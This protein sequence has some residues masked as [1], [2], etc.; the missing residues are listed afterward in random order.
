MAGKIFINYRRGD[1]A[2]AAQALAARLEQAFSPEQLFMDVDN[3]EPG[4]DFVRVLCE[5]VA[6]CDVLI[7]VIGKNWIDARDEHGARRLD[8][9]SDLVRVEIESALHQDKRV[10]PVLGGKAQ[11][12]SAEQLPD[13]MRPLTTRNAVRLTHERFRADMQGL[14]PRCNVR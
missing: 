11:T 13:T 10:I 1:D 5:Q 14:S 3:I 4:G 12:P 6:A 9:P 8:D 7:S 2:S